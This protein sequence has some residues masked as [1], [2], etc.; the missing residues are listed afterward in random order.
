[1]KNQVHWLGHFTYGKICLIDFRRENK[2]PKHVRR[3]VQNPVLMVKYG[4]IAAV[5]H[6]W[7][8]AKNAERNPGNEES[9]SVVCDR[10][11]FDLHG[12]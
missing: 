9:L 7:S 11:F 4:M 12:M 1:M 10:A 3:Y 6:G 8:Y 5:K 2:R